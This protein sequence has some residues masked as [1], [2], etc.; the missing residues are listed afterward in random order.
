MAFDILF[1]FASLAACGIII[2][3][4][5]MLWFSNAR[6]RQL[7]SFLW[8]GIAVGVWIFF[9][10]IASVAALQ[11]FPLLYTVHAVTGC[12]FPYVFLWYALNF[13][14]SKLID[15]KPFVFVLCVIPTLDAIAFATNP[16]HRLMFLTYDYP[17]LPIGPLFWV[18]AIFAY[19]AFIMAFF[20][21]FHY[22]FKLAHKTPL[23]ILTA[24]S[25][26]LPLVINVLLAFNL[27]GTRRDFTSIGFFITFTLFFLA[28]Y[29]TGPFNFKS[30]ALSNIFTSLADIIVI[31][32]GKGVIVDT[33][34]SFFN[35]FSHF[36]LITGKTTVEEFVTWISSRVLSRTPEQLFS[37]IEGGGDFDQGEFSV[38]LKDCCEMPDGAANTDKILTFTLRRD[39]VQ[40]KKHLPGFLIT[41]SDISTYRAMIS[42][43]NQ[44]NETLVELKELAEQASKTKSTFLAN[45]S[46]EIRTPINAIT[47]MSAI[48]RGTNDLDKIH[49]CINKVDAASRQLLGIIND[50]LDFSRIEANRMELAAEPFDL[51]ALL[52][53]I[54]GIIEITAAAKNQNLEVIVPADI[55]QVAIGDDMRLSQI[56]LNLLS[57]AVK[58][59]P[60][61]GNIS[62]CAKLIETTGDRHVLEVTVTDTG[63]G[64]SKEQQSRLFSSF[65]QADKSTSKRYGGSGLGLVIS[66]S[67]A[68]LMD[69]GITLESEPDKGSCF[70]VRFCLQISDRELIA[71]VETAQVHDFKGR[72]ALL[73]EDIEINREIVLTMLEE[74]GV[75]VVCAEN[76][77]E[78][79]D[80]F[81]ENPALYDI[82]FMD[83]Q[84]PVMDG[85]VAT[86]VI[87]E[88]DVAGAKDIPIMAMTANAFAEDVANCHAAGMNDHIS[89]P[90]EFELLFSK[91]AKL[92]IK[93]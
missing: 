33:N 8:F 58:F 85:Y 54:K 22:V 11:Y 55:P 79:V 9:S 77:K 38:L 31:A 62:L 71:P 19:I 39:I 15:S 87:R 26:L 16:I 92:M 25:T 74:C 36:P 50:I 27:L 76:G 89:K 59:T 66:K 56:F 12:L 3:I 4:L 1:F 44:Q 86:R 70:T 64:I 93:K 29:R 51:P 43:I 72:T 78:A 69:G 18:H 41:M 7:E 73:A 65:E 6:S 48:A 81:F 14:S 5:T 75:N 13:S 20:V 21:I 28:T 67:L 45:M 40:H 32:N 80:L 10:A 61:Y 23:M 34:A 52:Q 30:I 68:E 46:H 49:D 47:G 53:N 37:S 63:I 90:I 2:D 17:D 24:L 57:N 91:M 88:S 42:E 82:I 35:T 83:I 84:M 60:A